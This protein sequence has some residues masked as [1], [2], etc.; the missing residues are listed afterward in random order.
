M[1]FY[2]Y[3]SFI[4]CVQAIES[5]T[6]EALKMALNDVLETHMGGGMILTHR[7][8]SA[9]VYRSMVAVEGYMFKKGKSMFHAFTK[10]FYLLSGNCVY[11]YAH[12]ADVRP[13]GKQRDNRL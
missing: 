3:H 2:L 12:Q 13:K 11:Y 7:A 9:E 10:R 4:L 1:L 5:T 6:N 8:N